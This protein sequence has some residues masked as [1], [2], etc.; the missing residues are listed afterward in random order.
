MSQ[1]SAAISFGPFGPQNHRLCLGAIGRT[2]KSG[3]YARVP[4]T[5]DLTPVGRTAGPGDHC[6]EHLRDREESLGKPGK[7]LGL[8]T[9][10]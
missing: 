7:S 10:R 1:V 9:V 2:Q 8:T 3:F 6:R 5:P 4:G